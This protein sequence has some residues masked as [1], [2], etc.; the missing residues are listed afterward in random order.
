MNRIVIFNAPPH[1]GKDTF[2]DTLCELLGIGRSL[3]FA[4][5]LKEAAHALLGLKVSYD[6]F[7]HVKDIPNE[8]FFGK[9]PREF[10]IWLSEVAVKPN[11][12]LGHKF[13]GNVAV[14]TILN[15]S[16]SLQTAVFSDGGFTSEIDVLSEHFGADKILNIQL[17]REGCDFAFDSRGYVIF[18]DV[19]TVRLKNDGALNDLPQ[20]IIDEIYPLLGECVT[21]RATFQKV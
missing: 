13:F 3:K 16:N 20:K 8:L 6:A 18:P 1:A 14:R 10:Y 5:P 11:H 7:E 19:Q 21:V 17:E 2:A 12:H 4:K 15:N 9:T